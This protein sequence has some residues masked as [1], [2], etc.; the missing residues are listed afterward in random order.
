MKITRLVQKIQHLHNRVQKWITI[1]NKGMKKKKIV[2]TCYKTEEAQLSAL[3]W[4]RW[5]GW[6]GRRLDQE[7][8]NMCTHVADSLYYKTET[9]TTL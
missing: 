4:P 2:G 3:W 5:L 9:G 7:G 1:E 8:G 6:E